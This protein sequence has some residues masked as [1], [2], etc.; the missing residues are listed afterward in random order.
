MSRAKIAAVLAV[1]MAT[2]VV[3]GC[4]R[5][6]DRQAK[7]V[8]A[9][10][11]PTGDPDRQGPAPRWSRTVA[12][13]SHWVG[14]FDDVAVLTDEGSIVGVG[15]RSGDEL[16][17][18]DLP[19]GV[20]LHVV[21]KLIVLAKAPGTVEVINPATGA[22][23]WKKDVPDKTVQ[24]YKR[25]VY[26][27]NCE[28]RGANAPGACR[29]TAHDVTD[30]RVLWTAPAAISGVG[31]N[32]IGPHHPYAPDAGAYLVAGNGAAGKRYGAIDEKTGQPLP[33]H[34][35]GAGWAIFAVGPLLVTTDHDPPPGDSNCTVTMAA[36]DARTGAAAW[37][38]K[39]FSGRQKDN[40][41]AKSLA[42]ENVQDIVGAQTRIAAV[43][44]TGRPQV[45]DLATGRT[46]WAGDKAG[47]PLDTDGTSLLVRQSADTGELAVLDFE[48]GKPRWTA[49]DPGLEGN[50]ASWDTT[51]TSGLV[52]VSCGFGRGQAC[53]VVY[54][55]ATGKQLGRFPGWL[56]GAGTGWVAISHH[57]R[58]S[59]SADTLKLDFIVFDN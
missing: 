54:D 50:S 23:V 12:T 22:T 44:A 24:V 36:V 32:R 46:V 30:G 56:A 1:V 37:S 11:S 49:P 55:A 51:V 53:V 20:R 5:A 38:G 10:G 25:A 3:S 59:R 6:S 21:D 19:S 28:N 48:T 29:I 39:V 8:T 13:G 16:W 26:T 58:E 17:K 7:G 57:D 9:S 31:W 45:F 43:T 27:D 41:C 33:G 4:D 15:S 14:A 42:G 34:T 52:A 40:T 35:T 2:A 47:V 18:H